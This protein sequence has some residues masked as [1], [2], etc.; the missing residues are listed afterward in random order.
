MVD[1]SQ[2]PWTMKDPIVIELFEAPLLDSEWLSKAD[3]KVYK[4]QELCITILDCSKKDQGAI[5]DFLCAQSP[6]Y[7][8]NLSE[9]LQYA[10]SS[11]LKKLDLKPESK[12]Q[13]YQKPISNI[14]ELLLWINQKLVP[15][16]EGMRATGDLTE[17]EMDSIFKIDPCVYKDW[18][19][20]V[21]T[22]LKPRFCFILYN[23]LR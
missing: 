3:I 15:R 23:I 12:T 18:Q 21:W 6:S 7:L 4:L 5:V 8:R 16:I 19:Q 1:T 10:S 13:A 2:L 20:N 14:L 9:G 11:L 22:S 17:Q